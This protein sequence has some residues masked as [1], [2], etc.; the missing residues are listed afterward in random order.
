MR[1]PRR[2]QPARSGQSSGSRSRAGLFLPATPSLNAIPALRAK[3]GN[4]P[5]K[6]L[7]PSRAQA[8]PLS[9]ALRLCR[10][11]KQRPPFGKGIRGLHL[12]PSQAWAWAKACLRRDTAKPF[13]T[14]TYLLI[15]L[16]IFPSFYL[17]NKLERSILR[18]RKGDENQPR[19][20]DERQCGNTA[21]TKAAQETYQ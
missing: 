1:V 4:Q 2:L 7:C 3:R 21:Q 5:T 8:P 18:N 10:P 20:N 19:S 11:G 16:F 15:F 9:S 12:L 13:K 6:G 17:A 14:S